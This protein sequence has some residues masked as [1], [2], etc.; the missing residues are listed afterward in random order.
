MLAHKIGTRV[1]AEDP[2]K[3][4][5]AI[6]QNPTDGLCSNGFIHGVIVGRF[7]SAT[8]DDATI[9]K[10][11]PDFAIACE[12][13]E[14]W[15]PS[16]LDQAMCYH[17]MGHLFDFITSADLPKALSLCNRVANSPTGDYRQVCV[18][19][20]FM[21]I[22]QPLE[23]DDFAL[24]RHLQVKPTAQNVRSFCA[25]F[26]DPQFVGACLR[27]S[28]PFFKDAIL[29]GTGAEAFCSGQ[30]DA[31]QTSRCYE[32]ISSI[33]GRQTL[34]SVDKT[35]LACNNFPAAQQSTCYSASAGAIL[36][37]G[38]GDATAAIALCKAGEPVIGQTCIQDLVQRSQFIFGAHS[39]DR[40]AFCKLV[41][42]SLK[43]ICITET[44]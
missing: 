37:E 19:G 13:R 43:T 5:D 36:E 39:K 35:I 34:G 29:Q 3:W 2:S 44:H 38:R 1:V 30:P 6:P 11:L 20:V 12:P 33:V 8:L 28:W 16:R 15:H 10:Y 32:S 31:S 27:E 14:S 18:E 4:L 22:Y 7:S 24:I 26:K 9:N 21:Q 41:P 40:D 23:P 42:S 25:S 17:G